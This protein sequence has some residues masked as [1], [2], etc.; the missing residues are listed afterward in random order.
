MTARDEHAD[1]APDTVARAEHFRRVDALFDA[2]LDRPTAQR[3]AFV[4]AACADD[5]VLLA[6]VQRLLAAHEQAGA[7]DFLA[8]PAPHFAST[9]FAGA[10]LQAGD[11][12]GRY[13]LVRPVGRGGM[14]TVWLARDDTLERDVA[15]KVVHDLLSGSGSGSDASPGTNE[16]AASRAVREARAVARLD[17]PHVAGIYD[18]GETPDGALWIAMPYLP[19]G[20]LAD[21]LRAGPLPWPEVVRLGR[22][23]ASALAAAHAQ[24]IVHRDVKP[25]NVLLDG[26]GNARLADFGVAKLTTATVSSQLMMGTVGYAAP[27]QIGEGPVDARADL[28]ALGVT[29]Y[30]LLDGQRPFG[31][32]SPAAVIGAILRA[33]VRALPRDRDVPV[34]LTALLDRLLQKVPD[35]RP[36]TAAEVEAALAAIRA[37]GDDAVVEA[38]PVRADPADASPASAG[39]RS[40]R[41]APTPRRSTR[42][43]LLGGS[44]VAVAVAALTLWPKDD[45]DGSSR[46][47][48]PAPSPAT[49]IADPASVAVLP[50]ENLARSAAEAPFVDGLTDEVITALSRRE[51]L[52]VASRT[53]AFAFRDRGLGTRAL[54]DSLGVAHLLEAGVRR[55]GRRLRVTARL[56]RA[57][58]GRV[59]WSREYDRDVR[60]VFAVQGEL[61][62]AIVTALAPQLAAGGTTPLRVPVPAGT[63]DLAAYEEYLRGRWL[64][65]QR[66]T[67]NITQAIAAFET[68]VARDPRF[69]RAWAALANARL[70]SVVFGGMR[71][72][73]VMPR[74]RLEVD[75]ALALDSLLPEGHA[76]LAHI[77]RIYDFDWA[78][79]LA[80]GARAVALDPAEPSARVQHGLTLLHAGRAR[81]AVRLLHPAGNEA[82]RDFGVLAVLGRAQLVA[83]DTIGALATLQLVTRVVPRFSFAWQSLGYALHVAG[84]RAAARDAFRE[85]AALGAP[86]DSAH[87]AWVLAVQGDT[88]EARAIVR[89]LERGSRDVW[90]LAVGL[91]AAHEGLG[92]RDSAFRWLETA[93]RERGAML[94]AAPV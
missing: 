18:V 12:L 45:G 76:A 1:D 48:A 93:W 35:A 2:A 80:E 58:D 89:V 28:W 50:F 85:A 79:A 3:D 16:A 44:A 42:W 83:G 17:H 65:E 21:R 47:S 52:R 51:G 91:A 22:Q 7:G 75:R 73:R 27:E 43:M 29:L 26:A 82:E 57:L 20:S 66:T 87:L 9:F 69:A 71:P 68:A 36:A 40:G 78:R 59:T 86:R 30:E 81:E 34:A 41:Q 56:V 37:D 6:E 4:R 23:L 32:D 92:D 19:G 64:L 70:M 33:P 53:A 61:A 84:Q 13:R 77:L 74:A 15:I 49:P 94:D 54:G 60:D 88:A 14:G 10:T 25:A 11:T 39:A 5:P 46:T 8:T 55:D 31:G 24:G 72:S 90:E 62:G 67:A 63:A 38:V